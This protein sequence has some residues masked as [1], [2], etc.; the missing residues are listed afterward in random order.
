MD[1]KRHAFVLRLWNEAGPHQA[2]E[3]RGS[4]HSVQSDETIYFH[5][6]HQVPD[7]LAKLTGWSEENN[8][9]YE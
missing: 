2:P 8:S 6:L 5:S 7:I 3:V 4:I 9:E 1:K